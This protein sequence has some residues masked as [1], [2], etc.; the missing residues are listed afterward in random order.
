[1]SRFKWFLQLLSQCRLQLL[2]QLFLLSGE[3]G[4]RRALAGAAEVDAAGTEAV[5]IQNK[6]NR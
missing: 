1:M 4:S 5:K 6:S 3:A 2:K